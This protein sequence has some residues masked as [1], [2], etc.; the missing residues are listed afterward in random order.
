MCKNDC[1]R[2]DVDN[3]KKSMLSCQKA[4]KKRN[5]HRE[6]PL[7]YINTGWCLFIIIFYCCC[8]HTLCHKTI[9]LL[10]FFRFLFLFIHIPSEEKRV[11]VSE[12]FTKK[13]KKEKNANY[14]MKCIWHNVALSFFVLL[15]LIESWKKAFKWK[16]TFYYTR[17]LQ[18]SRLTPNWWWSSLSLSAATSLSSP[19]LLLVIIMMTM[20]VWLY[21]KK[22]TVKLVY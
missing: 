7:K 22:K 10:D 1:R 8:C 3:Y 19:A 14:C 9:C 20:I 5:M 16:Y 6:W 17:V 2:G 12:I 11:R 18:N 21:A 13:K 4:V 15:K